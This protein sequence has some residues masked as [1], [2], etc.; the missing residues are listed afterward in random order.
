VPSALA[1]LLVF[2]SAPPPGEP[3]HARGPATRIRL[4]EVETGREILSCT[5]A[6]GERAVLTWKNSLF[7]LDV[8]EVFVARAGRLELTSVTFADPEGRDPPLLRPEDL[9]DVYHTGG[10]FRV[11]GLSTPIGRVVFRVGEIGHPALHI[12]GRVIRFLEAVGFGGAV[13]L[14]SSPWTAASPAGG[15][16]GSTDPG[17]GSAAS[18]PAG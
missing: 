4:S 7:R 18:P 5:L 6:Q 3:P 12:G 8:T 13:T 16:S 17:C 14:Q 2:L 1:A 11:E 9:D 10:P 15:G